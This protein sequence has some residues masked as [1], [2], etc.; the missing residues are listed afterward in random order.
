MVS[1]ELRFS[2]VDVK[3]RQQLFENMANKKEL[4][5]SKNV[6]TLNRLLAKL[7]IISMLCL[8]FFQ[9]CH[10]KSSKYFRN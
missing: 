2:K 9:S 6:S 5:L 7:Y 4:S 8:F 3:G 1:E 10:E